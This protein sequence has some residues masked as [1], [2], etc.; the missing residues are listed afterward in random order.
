MDYSVAMLNLTRIHNLEIKGHT[1]K[2]VTIF[3]YSGQLD[4]E[5]FYHGRGVIYYFRNY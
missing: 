3:V 4:F 1:K 5:P 2:F